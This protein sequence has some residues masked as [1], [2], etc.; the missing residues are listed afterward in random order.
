M[1]TVVAFW[2]RI[3]GVY[4]YVAVDDLWI[5]EQWKRFQRKRSTEPPIARDNIRRLR[6]PKIS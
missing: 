3:N 4:K 1:P 5:A 6:P 2:M